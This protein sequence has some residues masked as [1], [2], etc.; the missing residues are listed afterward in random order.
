M[1]KI[2]RVLLTLVLTL[3][4]VVT[5]ITA[6]SALFPRR[7][8][9]GHHLRDGFRNISPDYVYPLLGRALRTV[10]QSFE[11]AP[12]RGQAPAVLANNGV[13]L[14]ANGTA[15]TVTWIGHSTFLVQMDGV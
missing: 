8:K 3:G 4:I 9:P 2:V 6:P 14:R 10:R 13:D 15:P 11:H 5:D 7:E 12:G 1:V